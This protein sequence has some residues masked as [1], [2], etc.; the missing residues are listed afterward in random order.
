MSATTTS[1]PASSAA[2]G[3]EQAQA[4]R[5]GEGRRVRRAVGAPRAPLPIRRTTVS[6]S[7]A[8][9]TS[10]CRAESETSRF[11]PGSSIAL[12]G[13]RSSVSGSAGGTYGPSP[14]CRVPCASCV[15][16]SSSIRRD[17]PSACPSPAIDATR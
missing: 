14:R 17:R 15:A 4:L 5:L 16:T 6:P 8:S 12:P 7:G 1:Y 2:L 3:R 9:S 10:E 13:K 11:P